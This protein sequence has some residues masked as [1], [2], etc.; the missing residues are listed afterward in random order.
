[1]LIIITPALAAHAR[2]AHANHLKLPRVI[3]AMIIARPHN[4]SQ[5]Q[6]L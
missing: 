2:L 3:P 6:E 5:N 1:M 4:L